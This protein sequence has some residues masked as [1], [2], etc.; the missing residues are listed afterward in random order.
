M[1]SVY[2]AD[3]DLKEEVAEAAD[4]LLGQSIESAFDN[5]NNTLKKQIFPHFETADVYGLLCVIDSRLD[6]LREL[7]TE[8]MEETSTGAESLIQ[9]SETLHAVQ[10]IR[11]QSLL[12]YKNVV[13][14]NLE[15]HEND[16]LFNALVTS[17]EAK[18]LF[19]YEKEE[20]F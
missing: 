12:I 6:S 10:S 15:L 9:L 4:I 11:E 17:A 20:A 2:I 7:Y 14:L 19:G 16:E 13:D 5:P 3:I 18:N 8:A 1:E